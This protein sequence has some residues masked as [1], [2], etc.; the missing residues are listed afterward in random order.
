MVFSRRAGYAETNASNVRF[1]VLSSVTKFFFVYDQAVMKTATN[2][3][4]ATELLRYL[5]GP[6]FEFLL[7]SLL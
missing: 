4:K 2:E 6:A 3:E 5:D 1:D 7:R